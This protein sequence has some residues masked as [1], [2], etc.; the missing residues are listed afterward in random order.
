MLSD[1]I[2]QSSGWDTKALAEI[3]SNKKFL[4][5]VDGDKEKYLADLISGYAV[6]LPREIIPDSVTLDAL[7]F[8]HKKDPL[9]LPILLRY[10]THKNLLQEAKDDLDKLNQKLQDAMDKDLKDLQDKQKKLQED[11]TNLNN[12]EM[13]SEKAKALAI[14]KIDE[15]I[16]KAS[17]EI[18][19]LELYKED[20][21]NLLN[22]GKTKSNSYPSQYFSILNSELIE[23]M[24]KKLTAYVKD[25]TDIGETYQ[26]LNSRVKKIIRVRNVKNTLVLSASLAFFIPCI[27]V[28]C[29]GMFC[30][31]VQHGPRPS[32]L[33]PMIDITLFYIVPIMLSIAVALYATA[34]VAHL[35]KRRY[36]QSFEKEMQDYIEQP[37]KCMDKATNNEDVKKLEQEETK[38]GD[39]IDLSGNC[40]MNYKVEPSA[41]PYDEK[42]SSEQSRL[43]PELPARPSSNLGSSLLPSNAASCITQS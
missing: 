2:K 13:H 19:K 30:M 8:T 18:E 42:N 35:I 17:S 4:R 7:C 43:Y 40:E 6:T 36:E 20:I 10:F 25:N 37:I 12:V 23:I 33:F 29:L 31:G 14:D 38:V 1:I 27:S 16:T 28:M 26:S 21:T 32:F 15:Q 34:G 24:E 9:T 41:P 22:G 11:R 3:F 5:S 39:L